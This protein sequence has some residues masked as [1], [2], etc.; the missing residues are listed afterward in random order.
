[1]LPRL[2]D[3]LTQDPSPPHQLPPH[4]GAQAVVFYPVPWWPGWLMAPRADP[5]PS[6]NSPSVC[7]SW[8]QG[9]RATASA[10]RDRHIQEKLQS[11]SPGVA[12][13]KVLGSWFFPSLSFGWGSSSHLQH[14]PPPPAFKRINVEL[15]CSQ[16]KGPQLLYPRSPEMETAYLRG[17]SEGKTGHS[18]LPPL[19]KHLQEVQGIQR[20][21]PLEGSQCRERTRL[22]ENQGNTVYWGLSKKSF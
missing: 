3:L 16:P 12:G 18:I 13:A 14:V 15:S 4:P 19:T 22:Q 9:N 10:N 8:D 2:S 20:S 1:M 11:G 21:D 7:C 5:N 6:R 17:N